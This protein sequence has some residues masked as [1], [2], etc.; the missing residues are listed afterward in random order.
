MKANA[1]G[2]QPAN[3]CAGLETSVVAC[4]SSE[5]CP[6]A[7]R[8]F[9]E[10]VVGSGGYRGKGGIDPCAQHIVDMQ[11]CLRKQNLYPLS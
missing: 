8:K 6:D 4:I 7:A 3:P 11:T 10:C 2:P 1:E 9:Q 5:V